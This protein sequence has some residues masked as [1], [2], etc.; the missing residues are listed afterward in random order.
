M[1]EPAACVTTPADAFVDRP[2]TPF[3]APTPLTP[4]KAITVSDWLNGPPAVTDCVLV[5][6]TLVNT[7][8]AVAVQISTT[9]GR[10]AMLRTRDHVRPAP[11]MVSDCALAALGPSDAAKATSTSPAA[12]VLKSGVVRAPVP[13]TDTVLSTVATAD[14][15]TDTPALALAPLPSLM[16]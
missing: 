7:E 10:P 5:T 13:S 2:L 15:V 1:S 14:T 16:E 9:P 6:L 11:E 3:D 12:A 8:G 4:E